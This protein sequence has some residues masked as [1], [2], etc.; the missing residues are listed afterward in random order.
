MY[1]YTHMYIY[2][3]YKWI[4]QCQTSDDD[5]RLRPIICFCIAMISDEIIQLC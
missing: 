5:D 4:Q 1:I 2:I 3:Y